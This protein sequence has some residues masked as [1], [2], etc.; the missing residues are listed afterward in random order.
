M[1]QS[2]NVYLFLLA[3]ILS[4]HLLH[5]QGGMI[6][7]HD[8]HIVHQQQR[9]VFK[10]WD[11]DKFTPTSGFLGL[12][13]NYWLTWGLHPNYPSLDRRPLSATGEQTMR[14]GMLLA[15]KEFTDNYKLHSDTL[16]ASAQTQL[17]QYLPQ[18]N[19][20]DVL[21]NMYY[22]SELALLLQE[23]FD[24]LKNFGEDL[25]IS[26]L[27]NGLVNWY[28]EELA[29]LKQRLSLARA[30]YLDRGSRILTYHRILQALRLLQGN[31]HAKVQAQGKYLLLKNKLQKSANALSLR[32][33]NF[34][35]RQTDIQ[36]ANSI[37][38]GLYAP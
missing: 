5:A 27:E 18:V 3:C 16:A 37:L 20:L 2:K 8:E 36:I 14:M 29:S 21:W 12:D 32:L 34:P 24:P 35:Q 30:S 26:L 33:P 15:M 6:K 7:I 28:T 22:K 25:K 17:Y 1:I 13:P 31:W 4:H 9:M 23:Q 38:N 19:E 11:E 10:Q